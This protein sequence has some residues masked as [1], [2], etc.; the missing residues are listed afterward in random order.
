MKLE[1]RRTSHDAE[2]TL[3]ELLVDSRHQCFTVEDEPRAVK[4]RGE[5]RIP[6]GTYQIK[7]R[8]EGGFH[9]RALTKY[10]AQWH[11]GMLWLQDVPGFQ[12]ILIHTGNTEKDTDGCII[13]GSGRATNGRGGG[14]VTGSAVAY[15]A[16]YPKVRDALLAGEIV[17][18]TI[19]DE[20]SHG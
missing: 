8:A 14:S 16:L 11:R 4:L 5:T 17:T 3:G 9:Q 1:L 18:I 20:V 10:G 13:V 15:Q 12:W 2:S 7:L 6:A 19:K